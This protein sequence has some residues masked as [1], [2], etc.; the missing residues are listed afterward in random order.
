ME[1]NP[2]KNKKITL[3]N[4]FYEH[5]GIKI[6]HFVIEID[7][8]HT[9]TRTHSYLLFWSLMYKKMLRL[10]VRQKNYYS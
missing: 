3:Q 10:G 6:E 2:L 7:L 1:S 9:S 5:G 4:Y 8:N